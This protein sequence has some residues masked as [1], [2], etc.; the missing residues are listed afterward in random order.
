[1]GA[2][3][4]PLVDE[5]AFYTESQAIKPASLHCPFCKT[6]ETY[7]LRWMVRKNGQFSVAGFVVGDSR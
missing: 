5:R 6:S 7:E 1:M 3:G 4:G 2:D